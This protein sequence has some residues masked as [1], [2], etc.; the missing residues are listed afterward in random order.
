ME[1][2]PLSSVEKQAKEDN[3]RSA[4][5]SHLGQVAA[6]LDWLN[7]RISSNLSSQAGQTYSYIGIFSLHS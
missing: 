2:S 1:D 6:S 7:A 3:I 5:F 4:L